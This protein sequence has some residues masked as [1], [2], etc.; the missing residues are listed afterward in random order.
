MEVS[1][2]P[3]SVRLRFRFTVSGHTTVVRYFNSFIINGDGGLGRVRGPVLLNWT[4]VIFS[5]WYPNLHSSVYA[6][7]HGTHTPGFD[8]NFYANIYHE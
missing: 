8:A 2:F 4:I 6:R 7:G 5:A 3:W 1:L